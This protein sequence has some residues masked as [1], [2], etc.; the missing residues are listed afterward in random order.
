[1]QFIENAA[2]KYLNKQGGGGGGDAGS[3]GGDVDWSH[4]STMAQQ[5]GKA[6]QSTQGELDPSTFKK[7]YA[8]LPFCVLY[9]PWSIM[10]Q[11]PNVD[12]INT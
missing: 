2:G 4:L 11:L 9:F 1:M 12:I 5:F 3:G 8:A 7:L 10:L 6:D